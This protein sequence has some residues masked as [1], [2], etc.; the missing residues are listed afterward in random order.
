MQYIARVYSSEQASKAKLGKV[1]CDF[2][3]TFQGRNR[4]ASYSQLQNTPS[5]ERVSQ[6]WVKYYVIS[7]QHFK[8]GT[9]MQATVSLFYL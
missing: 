7:Q 3:A 9:D 1:L 5:S 8:V 4:Y 2:P 6:N